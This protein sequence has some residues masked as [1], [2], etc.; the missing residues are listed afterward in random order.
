MLS[1]ALVSPIIEGLAVFS[2]VSVDR[3]MV[4]G[5]LRYDAMGLVAFSSIFSVVHAPNVAKIVSLESA[6]EMMQA[7]Q[8]EY[9]SPPPSVVL[10]DKLNNT[11]D[12]IDFLVSVSLA[13]ENI[14]GDVAS[15]T[16]DDEANATHLTHTYDSHRA[17]CAKLHG[18]IQ[19]TSSNGLADFPQIYARAP[20]RYRLRYKNICHS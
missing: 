10:L 5:R 18:T 9:I 4:S 3:A 2:G 19:V 11:V 12:T 1:G 20:R 13:P 16:R 7:V 8:A 6:R 15:T 14:V 17:P